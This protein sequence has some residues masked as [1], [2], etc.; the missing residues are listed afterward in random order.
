LQIDSIE[1]A[2]GSNVVRLSFKEPGYEP[3]FVSSKLFARYVAKSGDYLVVY[4]DGYQ[5]ISPKVAFESGYT[6]VT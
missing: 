6:K 4:E 2:S 1:I 3:L 5:S